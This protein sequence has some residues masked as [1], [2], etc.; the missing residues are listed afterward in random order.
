MSKSTKILTGILVVLG[1]I[2]AIQ[3]VTSTNSTTQNSKPFADIDTAKIE[4]ITIDFD[5]NIV[6]RKNNKAWEITSP[7]N[8]AAAPGQMSLLLSRLG[9]DPS[10][11]V[12][13][14]DPADSVAYGLNPSSPLL[15]I[16]ETDGKTLSVRVGD[17]TSDFAGCYIQV[18]GGRKI[19]E[20]NTNLRILVGQSLSNWRDKKIF[21]IRASDISVADF[22]LGD[23]LYH[24]F[25]RDT[26]W[27][28]NGKDIPQ[29]AAENIVS[30]LVGTSAI[31]FI[32]TTVNE[33]QTQVDFGITLSN[34]D[35][36]T[37]KIFKLAESQGSLSQVCLVNSVNNQ[38]Y[39]VSS[40]LPDNLRKALRDIY[41]NYLISDRS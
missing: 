36:I 22:A 30:D 2:Y 1:I 23:T 19:L 40:M 24:F 5:K 20:L 26:V 29:S 33:S 41:T 34:R 4:M 9:S 3:R 13:A 7:V 11:T 31:G 35:H 15:R 17:V 27:K 28:V 25:H 14:D 21:N 16:S 6:F 12:V 39:T 38:V 8:F 37:G 18:G 10:A 32:D